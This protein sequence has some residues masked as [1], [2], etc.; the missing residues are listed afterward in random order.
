MADA[1]MD[2]GQEVENQDIELEEQILPEDQQDPDQQGGMAGIAQIAA[3]LQGLSGLS[4]VVPVLQ[5]L[6]QQMSNN[7]QKDMHA[8]R[9][10]AKQPEMW[11]GEKNDPTVKEFCTRLFI[12]FTTIR[13]PVELHGILALS[14]LGKSLACDN[15]C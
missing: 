3:S 15:W 13:A 8:I 4:G 14:Y 2:A 7:S 5:S 1:N 11:H 12:Y 6:Q 10:G 9:V